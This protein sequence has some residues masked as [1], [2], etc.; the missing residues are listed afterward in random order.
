MILFLQSADCFFYSFRKK[1]V[2]TGSCINFKLANCCCCITQYIVVF[3]AMWPC[4]KPSSNMFL[5]KSPLDVQ[6]E[7]HWFS[8]LPCKVSPPFFSLTYC[9]LLTEK[10]FYKAK[11]RQFRNCV[12]MNKRIFSLFIA[13]TINFCI[14]V[15]R[16]II[17]DVNIFSR[18]CLSKSKAKLEVSIVFQNYTLY[19]LSIKK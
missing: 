10:D 9:Y 15:Q 12:Y 3:T 1:I 16:H 8:F 5:T 6:F 11:L 19:S 18:G 7:S 13:E 2:V 14:I 17:F 4:S